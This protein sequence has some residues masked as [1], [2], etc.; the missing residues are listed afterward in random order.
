M[1][2]QMVHMAA[3]CSCEQNKDNTTNTRMYIY[4]YT[5]CQLAII[6]INN[7][8]DINVLFNFYGASDCVYA[9]NMLN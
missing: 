2:D 9:W 3:D 6:V 7:T 1:L 5:P 8:A 4:I